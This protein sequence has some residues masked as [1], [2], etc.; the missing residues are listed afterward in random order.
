LANAANAANAIGLN[1]AMTM[2]ILNNRYILV[3]EPAR[4]GGQAEVRRAID[5]Q[6]KQQSVAV[7]LFPAATDSDRISLEAYSRES[8]ALQRLDHPNIVR[9]LDGGRTDDGRRFLVL[10]WLETNLSSRIP[11]EGWDTFFDAIAHPVLEALAYAYG[12]NILHRDLKPGNIL[13]DA[14]NVVRVADFG[15]SKLRSFASPAVTLQ[16]FRSKPFGPP[17]LSDGF[18]GDTRDVF[19]FAALCVAALTATP[20]Y[21][22]E[23]LERALREF[24]GPPEVARVLE[25]CLA[26]EPA[27]RYRNIVELRDAILSVQEKR[28]REFQ[29]EAPRPRCGIKI[30]QKAQSQLRN[31]LDQATDIQRFV[32]RDLN[33]VCGLKFHEK[34][35]EWEGDHFRLY[36]SNFCYHAQ[37]DQSGTFLV[38]Q[39]AKEWQPSWLEKQRETA[40]WEPL[41]FFLVGPQGILADGAR[42]VSLMTQGIADFEATNAARASEAASDALFRKWQSILNAKSDI[43]QRRQSPIIYTSFEHEGNRLRFYTID[44]GDADLVGQPRVIEITP[45]RFLA[46]EIE[47]VD[48]Q[49]VVLWCDSEIPEDIPSQGRLQFDTRAERLAIN[50]Q[51]QSLDAVRFQRCTRPELKDL[52]VHPERVKAPADIGDLSAI[53]AELDES[54]RS[55]VAKALSADSFLVVEGP[56][57]TGK[58]SFITELV[59][60]TLRINPSARILLTSQTHVALD[61]ALEKLLS[62]APA[63]KMVRIGHR[64]DERIAERV[65]PLLLENRVEKWLKDVRQKSRHFIEARAAQLNVDRAEIELGVAASQLRASIEHLESLQEKCASSASHLEDLVR[66]ESSRAAREAD[67]SYQETREALRETTEE[68]AELLAE[69]RRAK[70]RVKEAKSRLSRLPG[71]DPAFAEQSTEDLREWEAALLDSNDATRELHRLIA[72]AEEWYLRFGRSRDFAAALIADSQVVASTCLG[73]GGL[74]GIQNVEFDLCIVDEASKA[75]V[76]ELLV[77]ISRSRKWVIV[78][79]RNQL[80]PFVDDAIKC[81]QVL[82]AHG[83]SREDLKVTLLDILADRLPATATARLTQQHRMVRPIGD[84]ISTCF[85]DGGLKSINEGSSSFLSPALPRPVTW[86]STSGLP[87]R[88]E[89]AAHG[90][91]KNLAEVKVI[92]SML[93]PLALMAHLR[94][95]RFKIAVLSGY[96]EQRKELRRM[97][98]AQLSSLQNIDIECNTVDAFQGREADIAIYSATRCNKRGDLGFLRERRRLNVALSRARYG[99]AIVGD[100]TFLRS[101]PDGDYN[102][103]L[104]V[105]EYIESHPMDCKL[106]EMTT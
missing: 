103:W 15:I 41:E 102:P 52:L 29:A 7:K 6:D 37:V 66:S 87:Q 63:I 97:L 62:I 11:I 76:T 75:T 68:Q 18:D 101:A 40:W 14:D 23:E 35:R 33:S 26:H 38:I 73:F 31:L 85:Y 104:K 65:A 13:F 78:G 56:P 86:F 32:V 94:N 89:Q 3:K 91:F 28:N 64:N 55:A 39:G 54:K 24:D 47:L 77:P 74:R 92:E 51:R 100:A 48:E 1:L 12:Q 98:D 17:E 72:L 9:V 88:M 59:K 43:E 99:L 81:P 82:E 16:D 84:L 58:T 30:T 50:R 2:E 90:S 27:D 105:L 80:P 67:E 61:H 69:L 71:I 10:E 53:A 83:L 70:E 22:Y 5:M 57:G 20:L 36:A 4:E 42:V 96:S 79:D 25:R 8:G 34:S 106:Q 21:E 45:Q 95:Q 93:R 60:Q 44:P 19:G 49:S 46:G